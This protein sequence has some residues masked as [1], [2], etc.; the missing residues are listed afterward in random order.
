MCQTKIAKVLSSILMLFYYLAPL[1]NDSILTSQCVQFTCG[2]K[3]EVYLLD[4]SALYADPFICMSAK[5]TKVWVSIIL[6]QRRLLIFVQCSRK[7][8]ERDREGER[9]RDTGGHTYRQKRERGKGKIYLN[10]IIAMFVNWFTWREKFEFI[11][12]FC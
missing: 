6:D 10:N 2:V 4:E 5:L 11:K 8:C 9:E 12:V 1:Q 3:G 7:W